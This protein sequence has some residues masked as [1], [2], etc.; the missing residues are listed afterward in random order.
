MQDELALSTL[1][2]WYARR[3]E[4][5]LVTGFEKYADSRDVKEY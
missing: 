5:L 1:A 4:G 2:G 3:V